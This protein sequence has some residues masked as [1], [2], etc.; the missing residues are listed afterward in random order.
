MTLK[1]TTHQIFHL[2]K[3]SF[4]YSSHLKPSELKIY[5]KQ[6]QSLIEKDLVECECGVSADPL[7]LFRCLYCGIYYCA[8]CAERHFGA[9]REEWFCSHKT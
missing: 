7:E 5:T 6:R 8:Q 1:D 2:S 4:D 9:S 3:M